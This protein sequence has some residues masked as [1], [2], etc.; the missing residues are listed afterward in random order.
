LEAVA[1]LGNRRGSSALTDSRGVVWIGLT[2][3][4]VVS[5]GN[6]EFRW[7]STRD[8][9]D[10]GPISAIQEGSQNTIWVRT[11]NALS[12]LTGQRFL[13]LTARNGLPSASLGSG[14]VEDLHGYVWVNANPGMLRLS[15][16]DFLAAAADSSIRIRYQLFDASDGI[17]TTAA[18]SGHPAS[19]RSA[20]GTIWFITGSTIGVANPKLLPAP[21]PPPPVRI[22]AVRVDGHEP[23]AMPTLEIGPR[24]AMVQINYGAL[25]LS[26][27][28]R[29]RFRYRLDGFDRAWI[30]AETRHQAY[31]TN[32]PPGRYDF[33]VTAAHNDNLGNE[34]VATIGIVVKPAF[35]QTKWFVAACTLASGLIILTAWQVRVRMIRTRYAAVIAERARVARDIHD[36]LLQ[37]LAAIGVHLEVIADQLESSP[38]WARQQ[39]Q[40]AGERVKAD[41]RERDARSGIF[42]HRHST[43]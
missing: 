22:D 30:D 15:D 36:T 24:P 4:E 18:R 3:G 11:R 5:Y 38:Q 41:I 40:R 6:G 34:H 7:Y 28:E 2:G 25:N 33:R 19:V 8:G 9:L 37:S 26:A 29:V 1:E 42:D 32:L 13:T 12:R 10:G 31:Y 23:P 39:L 43:A 14:I 17:Q 35:Y 16:R 27:P 20:D 21:H